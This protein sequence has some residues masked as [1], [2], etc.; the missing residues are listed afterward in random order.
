MPLALFDLDETLL[1]GDSDYLWGQHLV[2][3]G[4][5]DQTE[6][7]QTNRKFYEQYKQGSLDI[8]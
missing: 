6:Y 4:V 3:Q 7:E 1:S 2:E 8:E 5:V